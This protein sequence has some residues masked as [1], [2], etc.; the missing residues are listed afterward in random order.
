MRQ[1]QQFADE[2]LA[3]FCFI[4]G[5]PP[6]TRD[7]VPPK[8][9]LDEPYPTNLPIVGACRA[10]NEGTSLDEQYVACFVECVLVGSALPRD[11]TRPKIARILTDDARL[12]GRLDQ[13]R[14][15]GGW[16]PDG[17][18]LER[19]V[20]K[21]V[22]GHY[23]FELAEVPVREPDTIGFGALA[24]MSE[25]ERRSF[26][27]EMESSVYAEVG[28]RGMIRAVEC[29]AGW[30][31]VQQG[32]YRYMVALPGHEVVVRVVLSEYLW[33]EAGWS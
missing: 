30:E 6:D 3:G 24:L 13:A 19:V 33:G 15:S 12:Q 23:A 9:F 28:S 18:R 11:V 8:V 10:C 17:P 29:S 4:C 31:E 32:R 22:R 5:G 7:H 27:T 20:S 26:E 16:R 25:A 1:L 14:V 21:L 2:R